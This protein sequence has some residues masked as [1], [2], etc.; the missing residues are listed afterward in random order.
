V[1]EG[2]LA[3]IGST[4]G[5][6][7]IDGRPAAITLAE[8]GEEWIEISLPE[9]VTPP[10]R[11]R[12]GGETFDIESRDGKAVARAALLWKLRRKDFALVGYGLSTEGWRDPIEF[13]REQRAD[14]QPAPFQWDATR[15]PR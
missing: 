7:T 15:E 5:Q 10:L 1:R 2:R 8:L 12:R 3:E 13:L 6:M 9:G 11:L 14:T 4:L